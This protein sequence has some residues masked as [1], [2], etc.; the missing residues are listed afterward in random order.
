MRLIFWG[1]VVVALAYAAYAGMM[2]AWSYY[3]IWSSVDQALALKPGDHYNADEVKRRVLSGANEAGVPLTE[4]DVVVSESGRGG[5]AVNVVWT[6]PVVVYQGETVLAV[7]L[8]VT[9]SREPEVATV[10]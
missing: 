6:Y 9:T 3:Q 8:S 2:T 1:L 4:R 7:P 10:R 5:V